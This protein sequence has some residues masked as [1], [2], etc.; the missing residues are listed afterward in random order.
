MM[1]T[2]PGHGMAMRS[3]TL[4]LFLIL[5]AC[6]ASDRPTPPDEAAQTLDSPATFTRHGERNVAVIDGL[7]WMAAFLIKSEHFV[8]MPFDAFLIFREVARTTNNTYIR[9]WAETMSYVLG[10]RL[11]RLYL[12]LADPLSSTRFIQ[13]LDFTCEVQAM[14]MDCKP[15]IAKG[16]TTY[17]TFDSDEDLY[18][19]PLD[20]VADL[21][22][23]DLFT[24]LMR[25][26]SM[27]K[28]QLTFPGKWQT[29]FHLIDVL[30]Y[31]R[32]KP[33]VSYQ[34]DPNAF[35]TLWRDHCYL[36]THIIYA[37]N[38]YCESKLHPRDAPRIYQY[39]RT[40]LPIAI[41]INDIELVGEFVDVLRA[42][43][44][45]E[46]N[47]PLVRRGTEYLLDTRQDNGSW[48]T[49][50]VYPKKATRPYHRL[51]PTWCAIVG[52][53][54]RFFVEDTPYQKRIQGML[55]QLKAEGSQRPPPPVQ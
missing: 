10:Y 45:T 39:T 14:G 26:H 19:L 43:G 9:Q 25:S 40:N 11:K 27:E 2:T 34:S 15:L 47:D 22:E 53:R 8:D 23:T 33:L 54:T 48:T 16:Q 4:C 37:L 52:L 36:A 20:H 50:I 55:K 41:D 12:N 1:E 46:H 18:G 51:H 38:N 5:T 21:N 7:T 32:Q 17:D 24:L 42:F 3:C 44:H 30:R 13:L 29:D 28:A 35:K 31:T 49:P 6:F